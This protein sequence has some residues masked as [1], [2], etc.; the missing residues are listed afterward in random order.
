MKFASR[1][2]G[3]VATAALATT[4]LATS[5]ASAAPGDTTMTFAPTA[6][7]PDES[8][9]D[10]AYTYSVELPAGTSTWSLTIELVGPDGTNAHRE[11][12]GTF[13]GAAPSGSGAMQLCSVYDPQGT[14]TIMTT[15]DYKVGTSA[16]VFGSK[17]SEGTI[18]V[19]GQAKSKVALK[20]KRKGSKVTATAKVGVSTGGAYGPVA[21][22]GKVTFQKKIG[23]KWKKVDAAT[24][25]ASGVAKAKF[26]AK[27]GTVV[28]AVFA[29]AGEVLVG[30]GGPPVPAATSKAVRIR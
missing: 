21:Q 22:G 15:T 27:K 19:V 12:F 28:R 13:S 18:Q 24:T 23:K 6:I 30:S 14:Y 29:G 9:I 20:A 25:N 10:H 8:C 7:L 1:L 3:A 11:S 4:M 5:P 16:T 26:K 2:V 17:V